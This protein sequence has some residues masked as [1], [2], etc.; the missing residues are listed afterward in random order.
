VKRIASVALVSLVALVVTACTIGEDSYDTVTVPAR[1]VG[2]KRTCASGFVKPDLAGKKACGNGKGH[3]FEANRLMTTDLPSDECGAGEVCAPD[4]VLLA[5]GD[6]PKACT[7]YYQN[8]PGACTS[9]ITKGVAA[10]LD[11]LKPDVCDEGERCVPCV[12]PTNGKETGVC[13]PTGVHAEPCTG[14]AGG[15]DEKLCCHGAGTC[16]NEDAVPEDQ[17]DSMSRETCRSKQVCAPRA[18]VAGN[19]SK[20]DALGFAD[21]VCLDVC[22]AQMLRSVQKVGRSNCGPTEVCMPCLIGKGQGMPGCD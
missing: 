10:H 6:K 17:R 18:M 4:K 16:I 13:D 14:G 2:S 21:G 7:F 3:C 20:C 19:P 1:L 11:Q 12:D 15:S 22:F 8:K 5:N 9:T